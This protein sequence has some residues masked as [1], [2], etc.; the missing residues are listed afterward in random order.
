MQ[1]DLESFV[2]GAEISEDE[3][4]RRTHEDSDWQYLGGRPV[5]AAAASNRHED[6]FSFL[7]TLLR[8]FL[9]ERGG[10]KVRGSRYPMRLDASWSPEPDLLVVGEE[11]RSRMTEQRLEGPA[12]LVIE[13]ASETDPGF[14][15]RE[16]LPRYLAAEIPEIWLIDPFETSVLVQVKS[17]GGYVS[18]EVESGRLESKVV[19]GFWIDVDWLW[20]DE[21][22]STLRCL[23]RILAPS[24]AVKAR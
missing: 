6:L 10:G 14:D 19:Q 9:D 1:V 5:M 8:A 3:F 12:D 11:K 24:R 22:P 23:R 20:R 4:Y 7:L 2:R 15:R 18:R 16:K 21:L 13:I 17:S